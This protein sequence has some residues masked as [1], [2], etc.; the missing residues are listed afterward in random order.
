M[1]NRLFPVLLTGFCISL[2]GG[3]VDNAY[4]QDVLSGDVWE[5]SGDLFI[6]SNQSLNFDMIDVTESVFIHN[7]GRINANIKICDKCVLYLRNSGQIVGDFISA[8]MRH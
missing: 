5:V 6:D 1:R 3:I 8:T 7:A 4:A 2:C